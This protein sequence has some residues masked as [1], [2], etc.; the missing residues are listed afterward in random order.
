MKQ[1]DW[2]NKKR[3]HVQTEKVRRRYD[4]QEFKNMIGYWYLTSHLSI[5]Q[6]SKIL[7]VPKSTVNDWIQNYKGLFSKRE[8]DKRFKPKPTS[9]SLVTKI[10]SFITSLLD[11]SPF[12]TCQK[13]ADKIKI[14]FKTQISRQT[15]GRYIKREGIFSKKKVYQE[16]RY[17]HDKD[18]IRI[19]CDTYLNS[20][21]KIS[22]DETGFYINETPLRGYG[23]R[24]IRLSQPVSKVRQDKL[25]LVLAIRET[26]IVGYEIINGSC[27][28]EIFC[29]FL[30]KL[31]TDEGD[32]LIMDNVPF[33]KSKKV[34]DIIKKKA[35]I[36]FFIPPY[37]PIF[38]PIEYLFGVL[39]GRYREQSDDGYPEFPVEY[40]VLKIENELAHLELSLFKNIFE[41]TEGNIRHIKHELETNPN[42]EYTGYDK[43][44]RTKK[45]PLLVHFLENMIEIV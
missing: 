21:Q 12:L 36:P 27:N 33:H 20:K 42:F 40:A 29:K 32:T 9:K 19:A 8:L 13:L 31:K 43:K 35:C 26:G 6:L 24:G 45:C 38:N 17:S 41:H 7:R 28:M 23:R 1:D 18:N 15:V 14:R 22:I 11:K 16:V 10:N 37:S 39:K 44:R 25:T 30:T 4:A 34:L 3:P 5:R 2:F